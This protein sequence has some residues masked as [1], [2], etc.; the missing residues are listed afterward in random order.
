MILESMKR[1]KERILKKLYKIANRYVA[2][3]NIKH[4]IVC[5]VEVSDYEIKTLKYEAK[6]PHNE[7]NAMYYIK[8]TQEIIADE[9]KHFISVTA[10]DNNM[11]KG[12]LIIAIKK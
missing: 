7:T 12:E 10:L 4:N 8:R 11:I 3:Y 9:A 2:K 1:L 6:L 5:K